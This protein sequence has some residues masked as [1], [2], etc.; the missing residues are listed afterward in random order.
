MYN[1]GTSVFCPDKTGDPVMERW[2]AAIQA[3]ARTRGRVGISFLQRRLR[4]GYQP[5]QVLMSNLVGAGAVSELASDGYRSSLVHE[6]EE[7][8]LRVY[9]IMP[10]ST[11]VGTGDAASGSPVRK[12]LAVMSA[13][14]E[15][16]LRK[17]PTDLR[18]NAKR[19][20]NVKSAHLLF[21]IY[22]MGT[23]VSVCLD[24]VKQEA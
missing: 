11:S 7:C 22:I 5:A 19:S 16:R 14:D 18:Q 1:G 6:S 17:W 15:S 9:W 24:R 4:I 3:L 8:G 21:E 10:S 20:P 12:V 23:P 2:D 13:P